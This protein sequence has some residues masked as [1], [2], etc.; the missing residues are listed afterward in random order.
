MVMVMETRVK[1]GGE[2]GDMGADMGADMVASPV[3]YEVR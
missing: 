2:I 1:R 3:K